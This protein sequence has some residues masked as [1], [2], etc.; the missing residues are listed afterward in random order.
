MTLALVQKP[1]STVRTA[2]AVVADDPDLE[3]PLA[4]NTIYRLMGNILW[5]AGTA[6]GIRFAYGFGGAALTEGVAVAIV[7]TEPETPAEIYAR[8]IGI[9]FAN[10][11]ALNVE[12]NGGRYGKG[13]AS[14]Y[15]NTYAR[16]L[17]QLLV[18]TDDACSFNFKWGQLTSSATVPVA[19][20]AGSAISAEDITEDDKRQ[21][22]FKTANETRDR[23]ED[24]RL[25]DGGSS[26]REHHERNAD[27]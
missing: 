24:D 14:T 19:V 5:Q 18:K 25:P 12:R 21:I 15:V 1:A 26:E 23:A 22:V 27:E 4:A 17:F 8:D 6:A 9:M 2:S 20:L 11:V 3:L 13:D 10:V 7:N 16:L